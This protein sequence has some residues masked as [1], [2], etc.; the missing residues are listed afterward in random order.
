M[1]IYEYEC[2]KCGAKFESFRAISE[3]D[4]NVTCPECGEKAAKRMM[5]R[6][7]SQGVTTEGNLKF[8]T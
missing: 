4:D 7:F 2:R 5:S 1:P 6:T 8:P 3:S